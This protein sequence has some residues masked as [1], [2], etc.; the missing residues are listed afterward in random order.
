MKSRYFWF[1]AATLLL[2]L[3][4]AARAQVQPVQPPPAYVS[5]VDGPA[6][7][8]TLERDGD[9]QAA[10]QNMPLVAGDRLRTANGRVQI[11][12]PDGS[13][14]ELGEDSEIEMVTATR[15][16]LL[17]GTLDRLERE[18]A[19]AESSAYL[20][21]D[22]QMYGST[23]D[24]Y[25][26]WQY[27]APYG[28]VWY[29]R[30][31]ASWRPY[32]YGYWDTVGPYGWTWIGT[33]VWSWPTH[34][35]GRW[36]YSR[37]WF[38]IP[39]RSFAP[40]WV[41]WGTAADYVSWCPLGFDNRPVFALTTGYGR[42]WNGWTVLSRSHFGARGYYADRYAIAPH[43]ISPRTTFV[44]QTAPP[45][46]ARQ[47]VRRADTTIPAAARGVAVPRAIQPPPVVVPRV[48]MPQQPA[49]PQV[50][51]YTPQVEPGYRSMPGAP[52]REA[53][54]PR[55][56]PR[57]GGASERATQGG[58]RSRGSVSPPPPAASAPPPQSAP[59]AQSAPQQRAEPQRRSAPPASAP[60]GTAVPRHE[61]QGRG[62]GQGQSRR[63][64]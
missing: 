22:L 17:A 48:T 57:D 21:Q 61:G 37:G 64:L 26:S 54:P 20:P 62:E 15:V 44:A 39:G 11:Q 40:A 50:T 42:G 58:V 19:P 30:V 2:L 1:L 45:V 28:Y 12:F 52:P 59:P 33:D 9:I 63:R 13:A 38:W 3:P 56:L 6:G 46:A 35:Y 5:M 24:Q 32:Y 51:P 36:G 60:A 23:F 53:F 34:H 14:I 49:P 43:Q 16:R 10:V 7:S 47:G 27:D 18:A 25:G 55:A 29:P 8:V 41:S 31:A 4:A